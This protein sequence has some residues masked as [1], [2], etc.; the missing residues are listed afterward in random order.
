MNTDESFE[1][2]QVALKYVASCCIDEDLLQEA[3]TMTDYLDLSDVAPRTVGLLRIW[4]LSQKGFLRESLQR[5]EELSAFYPD[6]E[7]FRPL[8]CVL[9]YANGVPTWNAACNELLESAHAKPESRTLAKSL[10]DGS[11]GKAKSPSQQKAGAD[12]AAA[13][14]P[15]V[16]PV[17]YADYQSFVRV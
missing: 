17:N 15:V 16:Q 10:L 4:I 13:E 14:V 6:A 8:L 2:I 5:C 11:F 9:R 3:E 12:N 7:E 1:P